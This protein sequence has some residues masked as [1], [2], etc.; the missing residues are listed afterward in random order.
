MVARFSE[1][2]WIES[3]PVA[4]RSIVI[5]NNIKKYV[6]VVESRPKSKKTWKQEL[7]NII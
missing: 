6:N 4:S 1:T 2:R 5:W 7:S 3:A